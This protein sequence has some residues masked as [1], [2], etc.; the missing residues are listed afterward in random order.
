MAS[1]LGILV[2]IVISVMIY[3]LI[4]TTT[5]FVLHA[6]ETAYYIISSPVFGSE[7]N[8]FHG[9]SCTDLHFFFFY[10]GCVFFFCFSLF[11]FQFFFCHF[12]VLQFFLEVHPCQGLDSC[13]RFIVTL[14]AS[15]TNKSVTGGVSVGGGGC[16][17]RSQMV[18]LHKVIFRDRAEL[19]DAN[20]L[21][22]LAQ[23]RLRLISQILLSLRASFSVPNI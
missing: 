23:C 8:L 19:T 5:L 9:N 2:A 7:R 13:S 11:F 21:L 17:K 4:L 22:F 6:N 20:V 12:Q 1:T 14:S 3:I 18:L 10:Q 16:L 15:Q